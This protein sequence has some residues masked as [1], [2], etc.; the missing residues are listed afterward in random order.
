MDLIVKNG[1]LALWGK[2]EMRCAIGRGG[3]VT[4]AA[5]REGDGATPAGRWV[6]REIW[7][8]PDQV[9]LPPT[10]LA[11]RAIVP[12]DGWCEA[13]EDADYNLPVKHPHRVTVDHLWRED[14]LYDV[15][16]PLGYNDDPVVPGK[17]SAIFL[18][19]ARPDFGPSAGC[20]TLAMEDLL[21][22][23]REAGQGSAVLITD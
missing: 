8:R 9:Q 19:V 22:V 7:Y 18:H 4:A 15:I 5:K 2:R 11:A 10:L 1:A 12:D 23:L 21:N 20:V 17:G 3:I 14:H 6:M 13:P 16:V